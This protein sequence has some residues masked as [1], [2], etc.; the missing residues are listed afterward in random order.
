MAESSSLARPYAKAVFEL[1][2]SAQS[3]NDW[4]ERLGNLAQVTENETV[5]QAIASP[6]VDQAQLIG[7]I[8]AAIKSDDAE[9]RNLVALLAENDR[10]T[11]AFDLAAQYEALRAEAEKV[12]E[13][14]V[15]SAIALSDVQREA[16]TARLKDKLGTDVKLTATIDETLIGGAIIRAGDLVVDG[17]VR[18]K[19]ASLASS[20]TH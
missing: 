19:L 9:T 15:V 1:A 4:S 14:E 16:I 12:T 7:A 11:V 20:L 18:A 13:A 17:S 3:F 2:Q 10:L 6:A 5:R 8:L